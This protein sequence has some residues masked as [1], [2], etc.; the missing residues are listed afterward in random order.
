MNKPKTEPEARKLKISK[1]SVSNQ[2]SG[3]GC[4]WLEKVLNSLISSRDPSQMELFMTQVMY[5]LFLEFW[6]W[7]IEA[8]PNSVW[9][10]PNSWILF[11]ISYSMSG[12]PRKCTH[13]SRNNFS[14]SFF[15]SPSIHSMIYKEKQWVSQVNFFKLSFGDEFDCN[16]R[17]WIHLDL[18]HVCETKFQSREVRMMF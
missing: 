14:V 1:C 13:Q 6:V 12:K 10:I 18:F 5:M 17:M 3:E 9:W 7:W 16:G 8:L 2:I 4:I 11:L 15:I